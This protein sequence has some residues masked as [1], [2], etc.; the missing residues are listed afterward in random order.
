MSRPVGYEWVSRYRQS[1]I[2]G[3]VERSRRPQPQAI[4]ARRQN[5]RFNQ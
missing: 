5:Q 3:I 1:G 2:A 4:F